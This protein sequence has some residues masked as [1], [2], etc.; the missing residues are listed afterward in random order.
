MQ[1]IYF[2][3]VSLRTKD[4][5]FNL[6]FIV[7]PPWLTELWMFCIE[8]SKSKYE[9][10]LNNHLSRWEVHNRELFWNKVSN[11]RSSRPFTLLGKKL[12]ELCLMWREDTITK[13][14]QNT[15]SLQTHTNYS[16]SF[17]GISLNSRG[18]GKI[19]KSF[20]YQLL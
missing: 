9:S 2:H 3:Y 4:E 19:K 14:T 16:T 8:Y 20:S 5:N 11:S 12:T 13:L 18:A 1:L 7:V 17:R 15:L 6:K 10:C